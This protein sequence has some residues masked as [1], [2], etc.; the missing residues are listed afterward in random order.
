[1]MRLRAGTAVVAGLLALVRA[2]WADF[3]AQCPLDQ[4]GQPCDNAIEGH[5]GMGAYCTAS[6]CEKVVGDLNDAGVDVGVP[7]SC[8]ICGACIPF[9]S[10]DAPCEGGLTCAALGYVGFGLGPPSNPDETTI[11]FPQFYCTDVPSTFSYD[12]GSVSPYDPWVPSCDAAPGIVQPPPPTQGGG[13]EGGADAPVPTPPTTTPDASSSGMRRGA[14]GA[15]PD[16]GRSELLLRAPAC[17]FGGGLADL[18][19]ATLLPVGIVGMLFVVRRWRRA[20]RY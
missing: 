12:A 18:E 17:A 7:V 5:P 14:G 9:C 2:A 20:A 11:F 15:Y 16:G 4:I 19:P 10:D 1:M 6:A 13:L 3:P 8:S